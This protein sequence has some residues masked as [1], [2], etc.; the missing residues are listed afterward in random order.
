MSS[1]GNA[2]CNSRNIYLRVRCRHVIDVDPVAGFTRFSEEADF[3][4]GR[5]DGFE[6]KAD[7]L[8]YQ[9]STD[10]V[11]ECRRNVRV[12]FSI[13]KVE[14]DSIN[15][16]IIKLCLRTRRFFQQGVSTEKVEKLRLM[17]FDAIRTEIK[18]TGIFD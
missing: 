15:C 17:C 3:V 18:V 9:R 16:E 13:R 10:E 6:R 4:R 12:D 2:V 1:S 14:P 11:A 7:A 8:F 5:H